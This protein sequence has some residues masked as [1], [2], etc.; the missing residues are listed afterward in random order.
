MDCPC[1]P[2][3]PD[4]RL[5][6]SLTPVEKTALLELVAGSSDAVVASTRDRLEGK[7]LAATAGTNFGR[8]KHEAA[9]GSTVTSVKL[10]V[11]E[12][13]LLRAAL[14]ASE[15][16]LRESLGPKLDL[17]HEALVQGAPK[18]LAAGQSLAAVAASLEHAAAAE[19]PSIVPV[20]VL[21]GCLGAGKTTVIRSLL[22]RLP[23]GYMCAWLKNEYGDAG[24]DRTV[25]QDARVAVKEIVNGCLCCTKVRLSLRAPLPT[26]GS[27][28]TL[29][30]F[31]PT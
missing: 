2:G 25:A 22:G 8:D 27:S 17:L 19:P 1:E 18:T 12:V 13:D 26:L 31:E 24:V 10:N 3:D 30:L 11:A 29:P 16:R 5:A 21:T 6:I 20:T 4:L 9:L 15:T 28:P 7:S 23:S 14:A